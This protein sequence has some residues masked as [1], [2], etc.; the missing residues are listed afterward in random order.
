MRIENLKMIWVYEVAKE[1]ANQIHTDPNDIAYDII[2]SLSDRDD[3][4]VE[5]YVPDDEDIL[6]G[7]YD[8]ENELFYRIVMRECGLTYGD[9]FLVY[10][11]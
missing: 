8:I 3:I 2:S 1:I 7:D 6:T 11:E 5:A 4:V 10:T 9:K